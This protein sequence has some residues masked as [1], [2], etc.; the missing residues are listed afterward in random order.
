[1]GIQTVQVD[2][3]VAGLE[4]QAIALLTAAQLPLRGLQVVHRLQQV[5]RWV[6]TR[7][8]VHPRPTPT[9]A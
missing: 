5:R 9:A 8:T 7:S 3:V 6:T 2:G 4:E 1:M